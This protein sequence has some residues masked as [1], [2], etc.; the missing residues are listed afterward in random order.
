MLN[1]IATVLVVVD[2]ARAYRNAEAAYWVAWA[3]C[4]DGTPPMEVPRLA[5]DNLREALAALS[6]A[7]WALDTAL[8]AVPGA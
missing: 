1:T 3:R 5:L 4:N 8:R 7:R 2:T 6:S